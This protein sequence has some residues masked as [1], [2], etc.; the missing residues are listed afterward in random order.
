[1][2][3]DSVTLPDDL[4][5]VNEYDWNPVKQNLDRSLSGALLVQEQAASYGRPIELSGGEEAGWVD[6][7]TVE[8]LLALSLIPNKVMTLT[9]AD[10]RAFS[11]I[12]D[13]SG[14]APIEARQI[15]PFAYPDDSYQYSLSIRLLTVETVEAPE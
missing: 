15:M 4:L 6:R 5:W 10:L 11:V 1:M 12:F 2:Q 7:A 14:G 13:R 9:T 3:L 8:Q